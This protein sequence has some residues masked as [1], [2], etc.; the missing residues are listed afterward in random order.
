MIHAAVSNPTRLTGT[1]SPK[2]V[3]QITLDLQGSGLFYSPGGTVCIHC[4]N[5]SC[6]MEATLQRLNLDGD[7]YLVVKPAAFSRGLGVRVFLLIVT[8]LG[9][10]SAG[11]AARQRDM[12]EACKQA[13]K[14]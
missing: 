5:Q 9:L 12:Q 3:L 8:P 7:R 6:D 4:P 10:R 1:A 11:Q 14:S 2:E 13:S